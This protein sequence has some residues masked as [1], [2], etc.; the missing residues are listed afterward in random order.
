MSFCDK[1][2]GKRSFQEF[3]F[4]NTFIEKPKNTSLKNNDLLREVPFHDK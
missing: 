4:Y 2:E 3:P 1:K